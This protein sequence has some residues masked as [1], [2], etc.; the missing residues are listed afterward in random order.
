MHAAHPAANTDRPG[1]FLGY[2]VRT[3]VRRMRRRE[4]VTRGDFGVARRR[5]YCIM[6]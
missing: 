1:V 4:L 3:E 2:A 5:T 6:G